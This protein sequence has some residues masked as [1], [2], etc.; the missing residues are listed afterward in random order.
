MAEELLSQAG[1]NV[2]IA[3][4]GREGVAILR[5]QPDAFD[6]VLIDIQMP[7]M[8]GYT[9]TG[10][11]RKDERFEALPIIA[12]TANAMAGD[13]EKALEA[14][15]NDHVAKPI[16]VGELFGVLARWIT[17]SEARR[18]QAVSAENVVAKQ[19][20]GLPD[21]PGVDTVVGLKRCGGNEKVYRKILNKFRD[22]QAAVPKQIRSALV[23]ADHDT[24]TRAA[25]T[26]KGVAGNIGAEP[27]QAA[28][29]TVETHIQAGGG[30]ESC[31]HRVGQSAE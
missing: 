3:N 28:A 4:D 8:D 5:A 6:G 10:E 27:V 29:K 2:S 18:L 24:A 26:L 19:T 22:S 21:I 7:V 30:R 9:A 1:I 11:I 14:G 15:M 25:H 12:M 20:E 31:P 23:A 17:V 16:D 13:R